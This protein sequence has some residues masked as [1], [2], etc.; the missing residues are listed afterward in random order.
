MKY[1][2]QPKVKVLVLKDGEL[3]DKQ[4][5]DALRV[6]EQTLW[7]RSIVQLIEKYRVDATSQ[8]AM[9]AGA[10]NE[11]AMAAN[12]GAHTALTAILS[13]LEDRRNSKDS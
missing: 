10:N 3:S 9:A 1:F 13:D 11:L 2:D 5:T 6:S 12:C 4:M 7:W 8:A